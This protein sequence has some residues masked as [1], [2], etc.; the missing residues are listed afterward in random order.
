MKKV[1]LLKKDETLD[2]LLNY[3]LDENR[4]T[5]AILSNHHSSR[6]H[7]LCFLK[8]KTPGKPDCNIIFADLAGNEKNMI[9]LMKKF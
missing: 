4:L 9:V 8:M 6:S 3:F 7:V 1:K 2:K 5:K